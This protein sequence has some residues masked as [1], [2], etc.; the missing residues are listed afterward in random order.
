M[1]TAVPKHHKTTTT[2]LLLAAEP[3]N[4]SGR[5]GV[6]ARLAA[7]AAPGVVMFSRCRERL[8]ASAAAAAAAAAASRC[9]VA[10]AISASIAAA[11]AAS[12][13]RFSSREE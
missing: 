2:Q 12:F 8:S 6:V 9:C 1:E 4:P 3:Y 13:L 5:L 10:T 7:D 11:A